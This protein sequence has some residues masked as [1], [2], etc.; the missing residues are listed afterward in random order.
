MTDR[1]TKP[2]KGRT[3]A[4]PAYTDAYE[5]YKL[6]HAKRLDE[7]YR[8]GLL[9]VYTLLFDLGYYCVP[10]CTCCAG[11]YDIY[12]RWWPPGRHSGPV[13]RLPYRPTVLMIRW[14]VATGQLPRRSPE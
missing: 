3:L 6:D 4:R 10:D 9:S 2:T 1:V 12:P 14:L 13:I 7:A 8:E 11:F 5:R